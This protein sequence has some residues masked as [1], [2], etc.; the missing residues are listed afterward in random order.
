MKPT[1]KKI[2]AFTILEVV[3]SLAIMSI[4]I[5][6][7]YT[8][9]TLLSK[10]LY[11]YSHLTEEINNYNQLDTALKRDLHNA[12]DIQFSNN[13]LLLISKGDSLKYTYTKNRLI[14]GS[15]TSIDT[16]S[17]AIKAFDFK[18]EN[19]LLERGIKQVTLT[20]NFLEQDLKAV[21]FK[22]VGVAN[23]INKRFF[24]HGN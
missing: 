12:N 11:A 7:V 14:R 24:K 1:T 9:F 13:V 6:M 16:F 20:Y 10:Q 22:D 17:V 2:K 18:K 21:Y 5:V 19:Q 15:L 23:Q 4:I 3:M 8:I